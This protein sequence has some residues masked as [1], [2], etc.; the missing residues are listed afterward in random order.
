MGA[1]KT[2]IGKVLARILGKEF[3]DSDKTIEQRTG[4]SINLIFDV[5][6]E[7]G[8]RRRESEV[9]DDLT[10]LR[11][12]V[13]ATGGGVILREENRRYLS[14]RGFVVYLLAPLRQLVARTRLDKNRPLLR[15]PDPEGRLREIVD[16]RDPLYRAAADLILDTEHRTVRQIVEYLQT[17]IPS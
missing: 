8:F 15:H 4:A 17:S 10:R 5:E 12:I 14:E 7:E 13:L 16:Q 1:G 3:H 9:I 2:T 11:N 6:G